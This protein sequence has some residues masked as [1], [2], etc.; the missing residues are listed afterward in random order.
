MDRVELVFESI[1]KNPAIRFNDLIKMT[2]LQNGTLTWYVKK[3]EES[4]RISVQRTPRV[5]RLYSIDVPEREALICKH[6]TIP[7]QKD[8]LQFLLKN[9]ESSM[10]K[11]R[12]SVKKSPP[13]ISVSLSTLFKAKIITKEYDIP[14]N[15][16]SIRE[17]DLVNGVM[18]AYFPSMVD[19]LSDNMVEM[20]DI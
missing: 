4:K 9:G 8:I 12:E 11:I 19:K 10:I 15:R 2:G 6:L 17:P 7:T 18:H 20:M 5:T 16:Y 3:L 13:V 14:S 1:K